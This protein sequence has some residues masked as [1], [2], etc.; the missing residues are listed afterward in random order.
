MQKL[1]AIVILLFSMGI[2][3]LMLL[4]PAYAEATTTSTNS[5]LSFSPSS[6]FTGVGDE[7]FLDINLNTKGNTSLSTRAVVLFEPEY[8]ELI[9]VEYTNLYCNYTKETGGQEF[10]TS[11]NTGYVVVT[12]IC[13]NKPVSNNTPETFATLHFKA[14]KIGDINIEFRYSGQDQPGYTVVYGNGSPPPNILQE[15]PPMGSYKIVQDATAYGGTTPGTAF[16]QESVFIWIGISLFIVTG[17][18]S[19]III[20]KKK[21]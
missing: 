17:L 5:M 8:V 6:G 13:N 10:G 20:L 18:V 11:N 3:T 16:V 4:T 21:R 9:R 12:G 15:K 19:T 14:K 2:T 7:F 1:K